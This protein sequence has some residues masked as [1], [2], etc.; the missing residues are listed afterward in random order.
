MLKLTT[1]PLEVMLETNSDPMHVMLTSLIK[2]P[3]QDTNLSS[4]VTFVREITL[5]ISYLLLYSYEECSMSLKD[6]LILNN[7]VISL[8]L[9]IWRKFELN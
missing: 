8:F 7:I 3:V 2:Q 4:L 1:Q 5:L 9:E 6:I